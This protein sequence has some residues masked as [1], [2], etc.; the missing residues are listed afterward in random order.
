M[1]E[2]KEKDHAITWNVECRKWARSIGRM[3]HRKNE[4]RQGI[5]RTSGQDNDLEIGWG[6]RK[7]SSGSRFPDVELSFGMDVGKQL[8]VKLETRKHQVSE[9]QSDQHQEKVALQTGGSSL[10]ENGDPSQHTAVASFLAF[11]SPL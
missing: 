7:D 3:H 5:S 11:C 9:R 2:I 8:K 6:V 1:D 4:K 10:E